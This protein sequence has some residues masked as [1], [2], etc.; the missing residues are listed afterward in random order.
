[1]KNIVTLIRIPIGIFFV[2]V[3]IFAHLVFLIIE[4]VVAFL[5]TIV[6]SISK[7]AAEIKASW[8]GK[9]PNSLTGDNG[10]FKNINSIFRWI[11][12]EYK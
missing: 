7:S 12:A 1:M 11:F 4:T 5:G 2:L 10:L 3:A 8:I 6:L 9:Y